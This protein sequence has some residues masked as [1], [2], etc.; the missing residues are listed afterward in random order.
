MPDWV[1][2]TYNVFSSTSDISQWQSS[3]FSLA[4]YYFHDKPFSDRD[5]VA[6]VRDPGKPA[7][8]AEI[9]RFFRLHLS[10]THIERC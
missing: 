1:G 4:I 9:G 7:K 5:I 6:I 8:Q 10:H 2:K 3:R